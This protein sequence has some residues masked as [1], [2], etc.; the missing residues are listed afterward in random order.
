MVFNELFHSSRNDVR[1]EKSPEMSA[2]INRIT[3]KRYEV[4]ANIHRNSRITHSI[5]AIY[6]LYTSGYHIRHSASIISFNFN[7][8]LRYVF[9][10]P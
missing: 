9:F 10:N 5:T 1:L 4:Q 8:S 2:S 6:R 7:N 3:D